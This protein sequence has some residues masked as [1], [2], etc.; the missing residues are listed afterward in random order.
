MSFQHEPDVSILVQS[1]NLPRIHRVPYPLLCHSDPLFAHVPNCR[2]IRIRWT[3]R[4]AFVVGATVCGLMIAWWLCR[5]PARDERLVG[6]WTLGPLTLVLEHDG[7]GTMQDQSVPPHPIR[8]WT[9]DGALYL[10]ASEGAKSVLMVL[11]RLI[12]REDYRRWTLETIEPDRIR[13]LAPSGSG[14][15]L[16]RIKPDALHEQAPNEPD[17]SAMHR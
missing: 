9:A 1:G 8:W 12:D 14:D 13:V 10:D 5:T 11:V 7:R 16:R 3:K 15:E 2:Q 6:H 17:A 4:R